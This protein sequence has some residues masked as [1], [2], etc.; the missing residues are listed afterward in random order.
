MNKKIKTLNWN[1][2]ADFYNKKTG[3]QARIR[4]M[5]EIYEWAAKQPE[6]KINKNTSLSF[7]AD[8]K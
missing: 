8:E 3:G 5:D 7:K 4:P 1:D 6:I 2:L